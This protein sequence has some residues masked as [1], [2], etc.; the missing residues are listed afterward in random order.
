MLFRSVN[1]KAKLSKAK[2]GKL[3]SEESKKKMSES[4]KKAWKNGS[5]SSEETKKKMA[6]RPQNKYAS[7]NIKV[8]VYCP[9]V[10]KTFDSITLAA[11]YLGIKNRSNIS[12]VLNGSLKTCCGYTFK[13]VT[14]KE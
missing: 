2:K 13:R 14:N 7:P 6:N 3:N 1:K 5:Y 11:N 8:S 4:M 12:S 10:D 9:E